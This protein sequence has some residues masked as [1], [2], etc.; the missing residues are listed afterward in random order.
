MCCQVS[1]SEGDRVPWEELPSNSMKVLEDETPWMKAQADVCYLALNNLVS[2]EAT[3][4]PYR[5]ADIGQRADRGNF[6]VDGLLGTF[7]TST[8]IFDYERK[9]FLD[10]QEL[11]AVM[12]FDQVDYEG[13]TPHECADLLGNAMA[14]TPVVQVMIPLLKFLGFLK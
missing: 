9:L 12:G 11:F 1:E 8:R 2:K 13:I 14:T 7:A 6:S 3:E 10:G 5:I 4:A